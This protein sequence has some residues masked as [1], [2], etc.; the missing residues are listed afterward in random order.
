MSDNAGY[1]TLTK[2]NKYNSD[3]NYYNLSISRNA[4]KKSDKLFTIKFDNYDTIKKSVDKVLQKGGYI[5]KHSSDLFLINLSNL[6]KIINKFKSHIKQISY[7]NNIINPTIFGGYCENNYIGDTNSNKIVIDTS[8]SSNASDELTDKLMREYYRNS[9][10][11]LIVKLERN[12]RF[13]IAVERFLLLSINKTLLDKN[14]T[15]LQPDPVMSSHFDYNTLKPGLINANISDNNAN[16]IIQ[17]IKMYIDDFINTDVFG[18]L[19]FGYNKTTDKYYCGDYQKQLIPQVRDTLIWK[20]NKNG[21]VDED[22]QTKLILIALLR[23]ESISGKYEQWSLPYNYYSY[24]VSIGYN[25]D[26][27]ASPF[28]CQMLVVDYVNKTNNARFCSLFPDTDAPFGSIGNFFQTDISA[29]RSVIVS[30]MVLYGTVEKYLHEKK[31]SDVAD[32]LYV[33]LTDNDWPS[34]LVMPI[35]IRTADYYLEN[36]SLAHTILYF[37]HRSKISI[38]IFNRNICN[39]GQQF[40][41]DLTNLN[42]NPCDIKKKL[43]Y[44]TKL[45]I[46]WSR[47]GAVKQII[48]IDIGRGNKKEYLNIIERLLLSMANLPA[49]NYADVI[50]KKLSLEHKTYALAIEELHAKQIDTNLINQIKNIID[51][52]L[53]N[54]I[55]KKLICPD[56]GYDG[57]GHY[58]CGD[59]S[60]TIDGNRDLLLIKK[61]AGDKMYW[62]K[63]LIII[64][65]LRYE[66]ILSLGQ[67]WNFPYVWYE[68]LYDNYNLRFEGF[69]SPFN[70]QLLIAEKNIS[71]G[72][73]NYCSLFYD[74]DRYFGSLGNIFDLDMTKLPR[75]A[76]NRLTIAV[77][78]PYVIEIIDA[79]LKLFDKWLSTNDKLTIFTGVPGWHDAE[80][81]TNLSNHKYKIYEKEL[82]QGQYYYEISNNTSVPKIRPKSSLVTF[83]LSNDNTLNLNTSA[84]DTISKKYN[85]IKYSNDCI[86]K[87]DNSFKKKY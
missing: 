56:Y 86:T 87:L 36:K 51:D 84:F 10:M 45:A 7:R 67:H 6:P 42:K 85:T 34:D 74:T 62:F 54:K 55:G 29:Y 64:C 22:Q 61:L 65:L 53:E 38:S 28:N 9:M 82:F 14:V 83:I 57:Y 18:R 58:Y 1:M 79:M 21:Y 47:Y 50:F 77:N 31:I 23:Y 33:K 17:T 11:Q 63:I 32:F 24:L 81:M 59:Y 2:V 71:G 52:F 78:P 20:L 8:T 12:H 66:C 48:A 26:A 39:N 25:C 75:S 30:P 70:S 60:R 40:I 46:E 44:E 76:D 4:K 72:A 43:K 80:F 73:I 13:S 27:M 19:P 69:A 5:K 15:T 37:N 16:K 35:I 68:Y 3:T 49:D 41:L